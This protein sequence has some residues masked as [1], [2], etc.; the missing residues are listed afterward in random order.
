MR[1]TFYFGTKRTRDLDNHLK[2]ALDS[3]TGQIWGDDSQIVELNLRKDY[4]KARPRIVLQVDPSTIRR[5]RDF[6]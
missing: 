3:A 2:I 4:D 1:A 6:G 5:E